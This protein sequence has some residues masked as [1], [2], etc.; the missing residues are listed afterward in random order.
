MSNFSQKIK[1]FFDHLDMV[2]LEWIRSRSTLIAAILGIFLIVWGIATQ[3][4]FLIV[5]VIVSAAIGYRLGFIPGVSFDTLIAFIRFY[6]VHFEVVLLPFPFLQYFICAYITWLGFRHHQMSALLKEKLSEL[7]PPNH[8]VTWSFVNE[9]RNSL[10][11]M[12]LLLFRYAKETTAQTDMKIVE[13]ELLR[14]ETLF[15]KLPKEE[16]KTSIKMKKESV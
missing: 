13:E 8:V 3:D 4:W 11:A 9:V 10:M 5:Q 2:F 15:G 7:D 6:H 12:R 14:L 16:K 1:Q